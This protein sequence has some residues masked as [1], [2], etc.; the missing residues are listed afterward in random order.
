MKKVKSV[1]AEI[2]TKVNYNIVF[3]VNRQGFCENI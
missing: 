3:I 2:F 1:W